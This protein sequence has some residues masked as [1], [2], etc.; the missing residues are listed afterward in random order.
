M[1]PSTTL[2][3]ISTFLM[4]HGT[5]LVLAPLRQTNV[6]LKSANEVLVLAEPEYGSK[7]F[8]LKRVRLHLTKQ[9]SWSNRDRD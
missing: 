6:D 5:L 2:T 3:S 4:S 9:M 7:E 8:G 1:G